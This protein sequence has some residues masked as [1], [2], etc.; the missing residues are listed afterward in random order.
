MQLRVAQPSSFSLTSW[1]IGLTT[2]FLF[3]CRAPVLAP[4]APIGITIPTV[5]NF[6][7]ITV[8]PPIGAVSNLSLA[9]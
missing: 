5:L 4:T 6:P 1:L 3:A 8:S 2:Y 9:V 7:V